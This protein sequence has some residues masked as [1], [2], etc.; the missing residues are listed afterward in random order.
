M[1][2][3]NTPPRKFKKREGGRQTAP[4]R[5]DNDMTSVSSFTK[6]GCTQWRKI[7]C[8]VNGCYHETHPYTHRRTKTHTYRTK[9]AWTVRCNILEI[10]PQLTEEEKSFPSGDLRL[11]VSVT[12]AYEVLGKSRVYYYSV[13]KGKR[14]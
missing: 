4:E 7:Y 13:E 12:E 2:L 6:W 8:P 11:Q 3:D 5:E 14:V 9:G 10:D 1:P